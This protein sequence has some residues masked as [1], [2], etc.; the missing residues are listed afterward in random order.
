[1]LRFKAT[2]GKINERLKAR[3]GGRRSRR[4]LLFSLFS[5]LTSPLSGTVL[6]TVLAI[7]LDTLLAGEVT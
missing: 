3:I 1:V 5:I 2:V 6:D 4:L 7:L